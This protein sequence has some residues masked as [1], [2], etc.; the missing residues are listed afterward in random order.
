MDIRTTRF[1]D[2]QVAE[3]ELLHF[4][5]G[6]IGY[7]DCRDWVLL[8]DAE[9]ESVGW[10]QS[11]SRAEVAL[12]VV[13]PRRFQPDYRIRVTSKEL[14][15]LKMMAADRVYVLTVVGKHDDR[16]TINLKAPLVINLDGRIGRQVITSDEQPLQLDLADIPVTF[17]KS[18]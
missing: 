18:A 5:A 17:R 12:A 1:G 13:S 4:P 9:N 6:L 14:E 15:P 16:L 8:A 7:E 3:D 10:L 11:L 2:L